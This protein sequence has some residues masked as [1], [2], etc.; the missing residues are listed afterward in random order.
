[1]QDNDRWRSVFDRVL[2]RSR[3]DL[4]DTT[5]DEYL[6]RS[7]DY[8][9]DYLLRRQDSIPAAL[10]PTGDFNLQLAKK[11]RRLALREGALQR[12]D[13]MLALADDFFPLPARSHRYWEIARGGAAR[14]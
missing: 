11:V 7:F 12:S 9:V 14:T 2:E 4:T 3:W 1:M 6:S 13:R 5:A 8:V 10:D